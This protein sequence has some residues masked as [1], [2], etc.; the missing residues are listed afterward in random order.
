MMLHLFS[1][2]SEAAKKS[3]PFDTETSFD[4]RDFPHLPSAMGVNSRDRGVWIPRFFKDMIMSPDWW[5]C[6]FQGNHPSKFNAYHHRIAY[7]IRRLSSFGGNLAGF[8]IRKWYR[9]GFINE[10]IIQ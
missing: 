8:Y 5:V 6:F 7:P 2:W 9:K 1:P 4:F 3:L 10:R